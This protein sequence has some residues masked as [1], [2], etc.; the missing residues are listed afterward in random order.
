MISPSKN[1]FN[2]K[3][4]ALLLTTFFVLVSIAIY[5]I[6][7]KNFAKP[8]YDYH[9]VTGL[10]LINF[11]IVLFLCLIIFSKVAKIWISRK[12][13]AIGSR[14]QTRIVLIFSLLAVV[15]TIIMASFSVFFFIYGVQSWFDTKISKALDNSVSVADAYLQEHSANLKNAAYTISKDLNHNA[16]RLME[17]KKDFRT[18]LTA[19]AAWRGLKDAVVFR[20][21]DILA[22]SEKTITFLVDIDKIQKNYISKADKGEMVLIFENDNKVKVLNKLKRFKDTYLLI[23]RVVDPKILNYIKSTKD[24]VKEYN[25][26]KENAIDL[27]FQFAFAFIGV[28][29]ILLLCAIW[30]GIVFS[31]GIVEP[32]HKL[33]KA[34]ERVKSGDLT[35]TLQEG[36]KNDEIATLFRAFN[37]MTGNLQRNQKQI[38]EVNNQIDERRR[39][40]EAVFSGVTSGVL[41][42]D[43]KKRI[44]VCNKSALNMLKI[45]KQKV[46]GRYVAD[47]FPEI[48]LFFAKTKDFSGKIFQQ[49]IDIKRE[50]VI[51][52]LL[53]RIVKDEFYQ[54]VDG[55]IITLDNITELVTAQRTAAWSDV[56]RR[57]A[58]EIKNPLTPITLSAERIRKKYKESISDN[59]GENFERYIDTIIRHSDNIE[60]IVKE[61]SEFARMPQATLKEDNFTEM[62]KAV[63]FSEEIVNSSI[64][65]NLDLPEEDVLFEFDREQLSRALL[66][67]LKNAAESINESDESIDN[68]EILIIVKKSKNIS[69]RILDTGRGFPKELINRITEPYVTTREK[70]TGLGLAIVKKILGDHLASFEIS[71]RLDGN[72]NILGAEINVNFRVG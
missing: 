58:H 66:N 55:Y 63:V 6:L 8:E 60:M 27:Q 44:K 46:V 40:I 2:T 34:T 10:I 20:K 47:I 11:A 43:E 57:I 53:V 36:A 42:L 51:N 19:Q 9:L 7:S 22:A 72:G 49:Q 5:T 26:L 50:G 45:D 62:L 52:N 56:A 54:Q 38:Y 64:H 29:L 17:N 28:S 16:E 33:I 71:N 41:S 59:E 23:S 18:F 48:T 61:F 70:G 1:L 24:S 69:L 21:K 31:A 30:L 12:K 67:L 65:Y 15:P 37:R 14:M 25:G 68:P 13:E 39:L 32:I 3:N 35:V 4:V